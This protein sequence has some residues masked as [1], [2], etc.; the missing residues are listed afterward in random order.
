MANVGERRRTKRASLKYGADVGERPR[1]VTDG[2]KVALKTTKVQAFEGS[3]RSPSAINS[4]ADSTLTQKPYVGARLL[5]TRPLSECWPRRTRRRAAQAAR[6]GQHS[7]RDQ[8]ERQRPRSPD[9]TSLDPVGSWMNDVSIHGLARVIADG[10]RPRRSIHQRR[11]I[12]GELLSG[13]GVMCHASI[14]ESRDTTPSPDH[15]V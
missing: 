14:K 10:D 12:G 13:H 7:D 1:T 5:L 3:N 9:Q 11:I 4:Y 2:L 15:A 8:K 6:A